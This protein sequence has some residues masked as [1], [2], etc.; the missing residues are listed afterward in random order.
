MRSAIAGLSVGREDFDPSQHNVTGG[1]GL[2]P[3]SSYPAGASWAGAEDMAGNVMEWAQD[4][5]GPYSA[6][7]AGPETGR[8]KVEKGGW[9]GAP[10][11]TARYAYR[12]FEDPPGYRD[13]HIGFR[14]VSPP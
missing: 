12:H 3:V 14:V 1:T 6:D 8:V 5:L 13:A 10:F 9:W 7:P 2:R 11:F 4:W